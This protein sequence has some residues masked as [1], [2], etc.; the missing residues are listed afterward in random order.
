MAEDEKKVVNSVD[1]ENSE[2]SPAS[3]K[4]PGAT[5][6]VNSKVKCRYCGETTLTVYESVLSDDQDGKTLV[7]FMHCLN[8]GFDFPY[9]EEFEELEASID[10]KLSVISRMRLESNRTMDKLKKMLAAL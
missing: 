9:F 7:S 3:S 4:T 5:Q 6:E 10:R 2:T 1:T 8:C